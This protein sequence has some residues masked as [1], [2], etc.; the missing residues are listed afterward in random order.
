MENALSNSIN[1]VPLEIAILDDA[2]E[3][4]LVNEKWKQFSNMNDGKHSEYWVGENYF[5]ICRDAHNA[6]ESTEVLNGFE[7]LLDGTIDT[8]RIEYPCHSPDTQ[9]WAQMVA[10]LFTE[11]GERYIMVCHFDITQRKVAELQAASRAEQLETILKVLTHDIRNPLNV[12]DAYAELVMEDLEDP[13]KAESIRHSAKR[14]ENITEA[15]LSFIRTG[16]LSNVDSVDLRDVGQSAWQNVA[17]EDA[18]LTVH[19]TDTFHGDRRLLL[20]LFENLFRNAIEHAGTDCTVSIGALANGFY[21]G[22][23]GPGIPE[24]VRDEVVEADYST[25]GSGGLGLAIVSAVVNAHG[26]ELMITETESGGARFEI[27]GVDAA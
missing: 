26:G 27:T 11:G 7:R 13:R 3:I 1:W 4:L 20:Q 16:A 8:L 19:E 25:H 21:V 10:N 17:T 15:T 5:S 12:I 6:P 22:D 24:G 18:T 9:R 23:N 2:G 14:I